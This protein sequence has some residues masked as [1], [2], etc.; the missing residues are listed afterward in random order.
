MKQKGTT[1]LNR[2]KNAHNES[3]ITW[4]QEQQSKTDQQRTQMDRKN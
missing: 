4:E 3:K 1:F 2:K